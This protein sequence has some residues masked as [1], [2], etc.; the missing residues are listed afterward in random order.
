[1]EQDT[2]KRDK[3]SAEKNKQLLVEKEFVVP[4]RVIKAYAKIVDPMIMFEP[5]GGYFKKDYVTTP[6]N[7]IYYYRKMVIAGI[8]EFLISEENKMVP[9]SAHRIAGDASRLQSVLGNAMVFISPSGIVGRVLTRPV[10]PAV[11]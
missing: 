7:R 9:F 10:Q 11:G 2:E 4:G 8:S 5:A 6:I 3:S 1:M